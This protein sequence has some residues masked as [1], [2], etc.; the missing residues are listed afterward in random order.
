MGHTFLT[1]CMLFKWPAK[2]ALA[3]LMNNHFLRYL[4]VEEFFFSLGSADKTALWETGNW[5]T[6]IKGVQSTSCLAQSHICLFC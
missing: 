5:L 6:L 4:P 1:A 3:P 2:R